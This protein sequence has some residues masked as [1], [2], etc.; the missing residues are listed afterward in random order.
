MLSRAACQSCKLGNIYDS[1]S[2][3]LQD[4]EVFA[5]ELQ[6]NFIGLDLD[7]LLTLSD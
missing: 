6:L 2:T 5:K 4:F 1:I 7:S 3:K